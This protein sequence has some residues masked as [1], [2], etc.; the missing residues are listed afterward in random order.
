MIRGSRQTA[1]VTLALALLAVVLVSAKPK[2]PPDYFPLRVNDWWKYRST[3]ASG[4]ISEF[5][6]AVISED[7]RA[8]GLLRRTVELSNPNPLIRDRYVKP[9]GSVLLV[10]EEYLGSGGRASF[11]PPRPILQYPLRPGASWQ[12]SGTGRGGIRIEEASEVFPSERVETPAGRF[13]AV[14]VVVRIAQGGAQATKTSWYAAG[15]G[16]VR[17]ATDSGG[18]ASTTDLIDYS[19][20]RRK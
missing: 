11:D 10:D 12:W 16:L 6:L 2:P 14:K 4:A 18:V 17:Q 9:T 8:D 1:L 7:K 13:D 20:K 5:T 15:I 3:Q 19:F